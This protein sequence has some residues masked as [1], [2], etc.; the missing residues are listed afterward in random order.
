[1]DHLLLRDDHHLIQ[2]FILTKATLLLAQN[3]STAEWSFE[4]EAI[5]A[6]SLEKW[7]D[8]NAFL[9]AYTLARYTVALWAV[10]DLRNPHQGSPP[11]WSTGDGVATHHSDFAGSF[12]AAVQNGRGEDA[13]ALWATASPFFPSEG[14]SSAVLATLASE[15]SALAETLP[16][17]QAS[18]HLP[19]AYSAPV[20]AS[21]RTQ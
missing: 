12:V 1:M 19:D 4:I 6:R 21:R 18:E 9:C 8:H 13:A 2:D 15:L 7:A 14:H 16:L 20:P 17:S 11:D 3:A 5:R 10:R